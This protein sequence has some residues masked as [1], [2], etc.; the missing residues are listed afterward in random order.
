MR[1]KAARRSAGSV[2]RWL[3]IA[4]VL[5][6]APCPPSA[7]ANGVFEVL[8]LWNEHATGP[9]SI[10]QHAFEATMR[11]LG[12]RTQRLPPSLLPAFN[13]DSTTLLIA[14][15]AAATRLPPAEV[16]RIRDLLFNGLCLITDGRSSL[17]RS[18]GLTLGKPRKTFQI[19]DRLRPRLRLTWAD[20]LPVPWISGAPAPGA[21]AIF[22]DR[23]TGNPLGVVIRLGRGRCLY[24]APLLDER[25]GLG[26]SRFPTLPNAIVNTLGRPLFRRQAAESYFDPAYRTDQSP[27]SLATIWKQ[28]GI[29]AI[30]AAAWDAYEDPPYDYRK[31]IDACHRNRILVYAW[32]EW[33]YVGR[34]FWNSHPEWRQKN[35]L[36]N[37]AHIDFLYLMDLQNPACMRR[38]LADLDSLLAMEWDGINVAE[39]TLTG[40]TAQGLKGPARPEWFTGFTDYCREEFRREEGFDPLELFDRRSARYWRANR[41]ALEAFYRYRRQ[42]N[43]STQHTLFS[44]L[45]RLN[46]ERGA[47]WE[48]ILTIADNSLHPEFGDL[49]GFDERQTV[50][51]LNE[52]N[53]TLQVEDPFMEWTK[54][55][56]RYAA[57]GEHYGRLLG[58]HPFLFDINIVPMKRERKGK[59]VSLQAVGTE[60]FQCCAYALLHSDRVCFYCESSVEEH[61]WQL[62]PYAMATG[63]TASHDSAGWTIRAPST[64]YAGISPGQKT[65]LVDD[66]PWIARDESGVLMPAGEHT[67][68]FSDEDSPG[69]S[70]RLETITGE[71]LSARREGQQYVVEYASRPRC[72]LGFNRRP[73]SILIDGSPVTV[74]PAADDSTCIILAPPGTHT[75]VIPRAYN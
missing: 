73:V 44:E 65:P 68:R 7:S 41:Q 22:I 20:S 40:A 45:H 74:P 31:L 47:P 50:A 13:L 35:A 18:I 53:V 29:R 34:G 67:L 33:P 8:L 51:L 55:P 36:R 43:V 21:K 17:A 61:D 11:C 2:A 27:D 28:W 6:S 32:L 48:L 59:F 38:A 9:D 3:L 39:F 10:D 72:A 62:M 70:L 1:A 54:P 25:S 64:V 63:I 5:A 26:Y 71:L 46:R 19:R 58:N 15:H 42:V 30:H 75:V 57:M 66:R 56:R 37:D 12:Y 24:L 69:P 23:S 4:S 14:P 52:F 16:T 60:V 49:L